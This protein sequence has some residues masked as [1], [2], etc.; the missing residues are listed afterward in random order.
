MKTFEVGDRVKLVSLHPT[1]QGEGTVTHVSSDTYVLVKWD[2]FSKLAPN[3]DLV[4][5]VADLVP[6]LIGNPRGVA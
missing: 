6:V 2:R 1:I 5:R 4:E 3:L